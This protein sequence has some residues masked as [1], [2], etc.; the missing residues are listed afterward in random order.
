MLSNK[1]H[2]P[3]SLLGAVA[4]MVGTAVG[5][6]IF[7]LPYT[8]VKSGFFVGCA[9]LIT[10][11]AILLLVN[12]AYGEVILHTKGKHQFPAYVEKYLGKRWKLLALFSLFIGLY[13]ALSAYFL[14]VSM[15][16]RTILQPVLGGPDQLYLLGYVL[17]MAVALYFGLRTIANAEKILMV[18]MLSLIVALLVIAFPQIETNNFFASNPQNIFLPYGVVLF[19]LAASASIPDMKNVLQNQRHLLKRAIVAGS[20]IPIVVYL[21]FVFSVVGITGP[22]TSESAVLGLGQQLGPIVLLLGSIFGIITMSTSLLMSGLVLKEIYLYDYKL[23][24][25]VAWLAVL[26]PPLCIVLLKF[27]S[28]IEILGL[29]GALIGGVDGIIIMKMHRHV[30]EHSDQSSEFSITQSRLV[31]WLAYAV[32]AGGICYEIY[33]VAQ[34][35]F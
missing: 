9:Y 34:R 27:L 28:F 1:P 29:S 33:V 20:L 25:V 2:Q 8:F 6:G 11:G 16:L 19:A 17:V 15:L 4:L 31:H 21:C 18:L 13:G 3:N 30:L 12:L 10:L 14:E 32:F 22:N 26:I 7:G 23:P 5:A 35:V 24:A